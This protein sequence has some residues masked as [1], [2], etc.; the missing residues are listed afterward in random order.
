M[1][2]SKTIM[3]RKIR[4][5]ISDAIRSERIKMNEINIIYTYINEETL[6]NVLNIF[7]ALQIH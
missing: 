3:T 4:L 1:E 2:Y 6:K 7:Y 5:Q